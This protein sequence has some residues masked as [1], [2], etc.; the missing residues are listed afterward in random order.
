[1]KLNYVRTDSQILL[2]HSVYQHITSTIPTQ[3]ESAEKPFSI[4][5]QN[6][7]FGIPPSSHR[8]QPSLW[9]STD[10]VHGSF[11]VAFARLESF[12]AAFLIDGGVEL[13]ASDI[14]DLDP[15][16]NIVLP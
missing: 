6:T 11:T 2:N 10:V 14:Q 16:G 9:Q 8:M 13:H 3:S 15:S 12:F 4:S 5:T 1:M 7:V